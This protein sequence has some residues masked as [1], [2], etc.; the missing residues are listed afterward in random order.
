M[1]MAILSNEL[2]VLMRLHLQ[3]KAIMVY[4]SFNGLKF[5]RELTSK[6]SNIFALI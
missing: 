3:N 6:Y 1:I 5:R 2:L 4:V